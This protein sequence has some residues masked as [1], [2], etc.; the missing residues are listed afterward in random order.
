M[1]SLQ[2]N[3]EQVK[4][5]QKGGWENWAKVKKKKKT[6][7]TIFIWHRVI[8]P[9]AFSSSSFVIHVYFQWNSLH[10]YLI[11][12]HLIH[13]QT[14]LS[15]KKDSNVP[16]A[17]DYGIGVCRE[18]QGEAACEKL[19]RSRWS[20]FTLLPL[21]TALCCFLFVLGSSGCLPNDFV[22]GLRHISFPLCWLHFIC[23]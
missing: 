1:S 23:P 15:E 7:Q 21:C 10:L 12:S 20:G 19:Q 16:L 2:I 8:F 3:W 13:Q 14:V 5:R 4:G 9:W 11:H 18:C 17:F 22:I 6:F